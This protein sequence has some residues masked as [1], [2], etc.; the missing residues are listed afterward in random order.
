MGAEA[1]TY[2]IDGLQPDGALVIG[3]AAL[4]GERVGERVTLSARTNANGGS[5]AGLHIVEVSSQRIRIAWSPASRST[6]YR[7]TW[8]RDDG[9]QPLRDKW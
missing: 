3:V 6:G 2:T 1:T 5:V 9:Q 4:V 8:R 7:I